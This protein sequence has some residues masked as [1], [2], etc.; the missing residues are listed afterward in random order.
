MS[1]QLKAMITDAVRSRFEGVDEA[2][3]VDLTGLNVEHTIAV[4]TALSDKNMRMMVVKNSLA[5]RAFDGGP[6]DPLGRE[7]SGPCAFVTGGDSVIDVAREM[8]RLAQEYPS[9]TLK[10]GLLR[11]ETDVSAVADLAKLMGKGELMAEIAGLLASPGRAL[12]GCLA[13]PQGKIAGCLKAM[14]DS[15]GEES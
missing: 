2:C 14:V 10:R 11:G 8:V 9:I 6:L 3:V 7:L 13:S 5:R 12:A 1:K 15:G 4:R